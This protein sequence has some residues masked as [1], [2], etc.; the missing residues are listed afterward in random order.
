M[1]RLKKQI[2]PEHHHKMSLDEEMAFTDW[3]ILEHI[4]E[5]HKTVLLHFLD[6]C[7]DQAD[8]DLASQWV[9]VIQGVFQ[10]KKLLPNSH[11]ELHNLVNDVIYTVAT[12]KHDPLPLQKSEYIAAKIIAF[13]D[14]HLFTGVIDRL[15]TRKKNE[16]YELVAEIQTHHPKMA[17]IDNLARLE[18]AYQIQEEE[19]KDFITFFGADEIVLSGQ[20]LTGKMKE[21]YHYR[22][23]QKKQGGTSIAKTFQEKY[24]QLPQPPSFDHLPQIE[25][26]EDIGIIYDKTE[27][28][29]LLVNYSQFESVFQREDFKRI[30]GYRQ[31]VMGYLEDPNISALPFLRMAKRY[32]ENTAK[33]FQ[34]IL[35]R[36][37]FSLDKDL[38]KLLKKYKPMAEMMHFTPAII[39]SLVKS[40]TFLKSLKAG[41]KW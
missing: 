10:V 2:F 9:N 3:F 25:S 13:Q 11:F 15:P 36:K 41:N 20:N 1:L 7:T 4:L 40:K 17:F 22:Y 31:L 26:L 14:Y 8:V 34:A 28:M 12:F 23:F 18:M 21:F 38:P 16:I 35:K 24:H 19:L 6:T 32:P 5:D 27:G 39:P 33:V 29:M 37:R 30:K